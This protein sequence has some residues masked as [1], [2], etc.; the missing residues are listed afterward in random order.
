MIKLN[1]GTAGASVRAGE[2][3]TLRA[4][5]LAALGTTDAYYYV[6]DTAGTQLGYNRLGLASSYLPGRYRMRVNNSDTV[7]AVEADRA[8]QVATGTL[9]VNGPGTDYYY[10]LDATGRQLGYSRMSTPL[11]F[12]PGSY[13]VRLGGRTT[14][15]SVRADSAA[16][17]RP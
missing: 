12:L 1:N 5:T 2:T 11:S 8:A 17:A 16:V 10:V 15:A 4:G 6:L 14:S 7:V 9:V 3:T 13:S